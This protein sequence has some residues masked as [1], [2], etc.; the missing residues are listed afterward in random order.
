MAQFSK[1]HTRAAKLL[2]E[3]VVQ[4]RELYHKF[5]RSQASLSREFGVTE[6]T[7]GRIVRGTS[8]QAY[9]GPGEHVGAREASDAQLL[10]EAALEENARINAPAM[11]SP[12][13]QESLAKLARLGIQPKPEETEHDLPTQTS[14][15]HTADDRRSG[16]GDVPSGDLPVDQRGETEVEGAGGSPGKGEGG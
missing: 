6:G 16:D 1:Y 10:H 13:I 4:I 12:E 11:D 15:L 3:Q 14:D 9:G 5:N 8:W 7:I 2:P